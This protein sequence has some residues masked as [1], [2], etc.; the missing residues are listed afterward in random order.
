MAE[1]HINRD[2][3]SGVIESYKEINE[4]F[5]LR[6]FLGNDSQK[7]LK[8]FIHGKECRIKFYLKKNTVKLQPIGQNI[9]CSNL[10]IDYIV[11]KGQPAEIETKQFTFPCSTKI[12]D[13]LITY[14]QDECSELISLSQSNNI[15]RFKGYNE[16]TLILTFYPTSNKAMIQGKPLQVYSLI[17][18]YLST[19]SD[20]S[21]EQINEINNTFNNTKLTVT[22]LRNDIKTQIG[23]AYSYLDEALLKC[24]SG[25]FSLLNQKGICEDYTGCLTG[26]FRALEGYLKKIL[27]QKFGYKISRDRTFSMFYKESGN[28]EIDRDSNISLEIKT[29]LTK[30][31]SLY[32][33]KRNVYLHT[34][35]NPV[36]TS[37]IETLDEAQNLSNDILSK[38]KQSYTV[39]FS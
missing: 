7:E 13:S 29:E 14:I 11:S 10:L 37:I 20:Y 22:E 21:F 6:S 30:L 18:T 3:L 35:V 32:S 15:Y 38:I 33:N 34:T 26:I 27:T 9:E 28:S 39:I 5:V 2:A 23:D 8:C 16:D 17:I 25:S 36:Y 19:I 31:Y 12:V 4:T 24:I 1:I